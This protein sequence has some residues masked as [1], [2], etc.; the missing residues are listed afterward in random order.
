MSIFY[1]LVQCLGLLITLFS[2]IRI[3]ELCGLKW[4][5]INFKSRTFAVERTIERIADL[6]GGSAKKNEG[7]Y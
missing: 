5:D 3:G 7:Y 6:D 4:G 1:R 2:G